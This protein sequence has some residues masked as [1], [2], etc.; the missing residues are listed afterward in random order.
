MTGLPAA[1]PACAVCDLS[2]PIDQPHD[3]ESSTYKLGF[4]L[5][6]DRWPTW[7][8]AIAHCDVR[9]R[10]AA[11]LDLRRRGLWPMGKWEAE[12]TLRE[13]SS[14]GTNLLSGLATIGPA[15]LG[16]PEGSDR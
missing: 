12:R 1:K 7:K 15:R 2:H 10:I 6:H 9:T 3:V 13:R 8:D 11:E 14:A 5:E 4:W 16:I